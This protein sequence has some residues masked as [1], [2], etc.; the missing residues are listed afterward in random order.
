M[1]NNSILAWWIRNPIAANLAMLILVVAGS[2]SYLLTIEKEP[3]PTVRLPIMDVRMTWQGASPR[4]I[5]DQ[6]IVRFEEAVKNVEGIKSIVS[7]AFE[8][9]AQ[10]TITGEERVDRR[11]FSDD[12][13]EKINSVN[14]LP[15]DADRPIVTERIKRD[16]MIRIALHGNINELTLNKL[17]QEI[18]REVAAL[19]LITNVDI[20]GNINEEISIQVTERKLRQ[21]GLSFNEIESAVR[22]NSIN[23][24]AGSVYGETETFRLNVRN[25]AEKQI[26]F[27]KIILRHSAD[28]AILTLGDVATIYDGLAASKRYSSFD[29]ETALLIDVYNGDYM[30]IV[31][32]SA[33]VREYIKEKI[34]HLPTGVSLTIWEDWNDA[35]QSRL[36]TIFKSALSGLILVFSLLLLFLQPRIAVWVSIGIGTT[37]AAAFW[38]LPSFSVSLNMLS[39]FAFMMVIG[40]VV[41]DAIVIGESIHKQHELGHHGA[42][43]ALLGV[44]A[45][46]KPVV[47]GVLTTI[48]VFMPMAFLPGSTAEFTRTIAIVVMLALAFSLFEALFILPSHLRHLPDD[49]ADNSPSKLAL[50][51]QKFADFLAWLGNNIYGP[52]IDVLLAYR[53]LVVAVFILVFSL[54]VKLLNDNF[55]LQS[56]EPKIEADTIRLNV[57]LPENVSFERMNQVLDQMNAGQALL[58]QHVAKLSLDGNGQFIDHHYSRISGSRISSYLKLVPYEQRIIDT[59]TATKRLTE[60][61]GDIPDAEEIEFKA[62]LNEREPRVAF[63]VQSHNLDAMTVAVKELKNHLAEYDDVYLVR[64]SLAR[65]SKEI[66]LTMK[67]GAAALGVSL[68]DISQQVKQAFYGQEV[69]RLPREG[70]DSRVRVHYSRAEREDI[71]S[72]YALKVR[73]RNKIEIPLINLVN[74]E[75]KPGVSRIQRRDGMK[76]AWVWADYAG[77][78]LNALK[79]SI[80]KEY[81]VAWAKRHPEVNMDRKGRSRNQDEFMDKVYHYEGLALLIAYVLMAVAFKSY[82]QPLLIMSAIPFA[83]T[84]SIFGHLAH[85]VYF[86]AFSMLGILAAA[87]VV[88]NDNIVLVDCLNNLRAKGSSPLMAVK[89][90]CRARFRAITLTSFTTFVGL[91]PML[92][93]DTEQAKFLVPMVVSLAYGI[94]FAT[95]TT[96]ILTPCLYL[97]GIDINIVTNKAHHLWKHLDKA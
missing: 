29:G 44:Q 41:D 20:S 96:L 47:F 77:N 87:G 37:F 14:G 58:T 39:L 46:A 64:D 97:I 62:T 15:S 25:R 57:T 72:L 34:Q 78:N 18:R 82:S 49:D 68:K 51:Q 19:P 60:Y 79:E 43:A 69:Q 10:V 42:K 76:V 5:E 52:V 36:D 6:I 45:V 35:Y 26:D 33:N 74:I 81:L 84:G 7:N 55:I 48:I 61:I 11:K 28:G 16:Q 91:I 63:M 56:F 75:L 94:I 22:N 73:T 80:R 66:M 4:D 54:S 71:D 70:G 90:A 85:Q 53:Y 1:H 3:F 93:G 50:L 32:M 92:S 17:A 67:P 2:M 59:D 65:G 30:D 8:G 83:F 27:E 9:R 86:G 88:V 38:L 21:F 89:A 12:V 23:T 13:R 95:L 24:S 40:I 31:Q